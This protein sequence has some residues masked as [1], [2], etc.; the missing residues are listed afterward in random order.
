MLKLVSPLELIFNMVNPYEALDI[1]SQEV[2]QELILTL[3]IFFE[4]V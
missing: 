4:I 1:A 2:S 3:N